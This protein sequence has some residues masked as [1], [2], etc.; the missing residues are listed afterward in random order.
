MLGQDPGLLGGIYAFVILSSIILVY[1]T[2]QQQLTGITCI[3][4]L[5]IFC[6]QR[7]I[8]GDLVGSWSSLFSKPQ[9]DRM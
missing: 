7:E 3:L 4:P 5:K 2:K 9:P 8:I 1:S 6:C